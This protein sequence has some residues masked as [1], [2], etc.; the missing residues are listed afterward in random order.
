[1]IFRFLTLFCLLSLLGTNGIAQKDSAKKLQILVF[2][3]LTRSIETSW[4]FG[5]AGT[6]TFRMSAS[7]T[8][9]RTSNL[10]TI[11]LYSLKKQLVAAINGAQYFK[12]EQYVLNEQISYSSFPDKFWGLGNQTLDQAEEAYD[13]QQ[14]YTY[15]HLMRQV[16]KGM[17]I[18]GLYEYQNLLETN[19]KAGGIFDQE[20]VVGRK[21]YHISGL[22]LSF[23]IDT[24]NNA[25]APT[26]GN[27]AQIYFNHFTPVFGS[28]HRY[29]N[30]VIDL[31]KYM[32]FRKNGVLAL[33]AYSFNN[34]GNDVPLRSLATLGGMNSMRGYYDG[35]YRDKN[36]LV[37]QAEFRQH[38]FKRFGAVAF[39]N[40]GDVSHNLAY[41]LADLKY[42]FGAGLRY[43]I[44]K[45]EKLNIR[46]DYGMGPG[47]NHGFYFELG[48]A[49]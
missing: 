1:M 26:K 30:I 49:F 16:G 37:F 46:L 15:L 33:Q 45:S 47:K 23:T 40:I 42:S 12:N 31:R 41:Q 4:S 2:P 24:R 48:E 10:Q 13:F 6:S 5:V 21:G 39:G 36:Q 28:E 9:S 34:T 8:I 43:A 44:N 20:Q 27:F 22:G 11:V 18:G 19:Y 38:L 32:T 35:R 7:D 25:F 14:F 17:F 29:T 3:V